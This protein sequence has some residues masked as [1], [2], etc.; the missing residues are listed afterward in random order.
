VRVVASKSDFTYLLV[1]F[2]KP[3]SSSRLIVVSAVG[4]S[5]LQVAD[6]GGIAKWSKKGSYFGTWNVQGFFL[7]DAIQSGRAV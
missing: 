2:I 5:A 1:A 3:L 6:L 7:A 4:H